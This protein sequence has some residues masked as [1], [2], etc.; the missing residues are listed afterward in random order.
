MPFRSFI[1]SS[2]FASQ[3]HL[4]PIVVTLWIVSRLDVDV[5]SLHE[6]TTSRWYG[7]K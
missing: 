2:K 3:P 6:V 5:G 4:M 7:E 1:S